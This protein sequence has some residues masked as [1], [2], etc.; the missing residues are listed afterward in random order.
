MESLLQKD[1]FSWISRIF[2]RGRGPTAAQDKI[3]EVVDLFNSYKGCFHFL[4]PTEIW[5]VSSSPGASLCITIPLRNNEKAV[6]NQQ[7]ASQSRNHSMEGEANLEP[8][9]PVPAQIE[10]K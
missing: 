4:F 10:I 5:W 3:K 7:D 2:Q 8:R 9:F 1:T 6:Q